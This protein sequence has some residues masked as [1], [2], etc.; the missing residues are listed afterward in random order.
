MEGVGLNYLSPVGDG[1][2]SAHFSSVN[3]L[4]N[5]L[6]SEDL[7]S[8]LIGCFAVDF[9]PCGKLFSATFNLNHVD[10]ACIEG[11]DKIVCG[12]NPL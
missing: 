11:V 10:A 1:F 4:A 9:A 5:F 8:G 7:P 3:K 12:I 6:N 2:Y